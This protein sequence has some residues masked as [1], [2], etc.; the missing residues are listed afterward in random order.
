MF[1]TNNSASVNSA[2]THE[3]LATAVT[4][5]LKQT[6]DF[7][8]SNK[9]LKVPIHF[10]YPI[11]CSTNNEQQAVHFILIWTFTTLQLVPL[12]EICCE[13][14]SHLYCCYLCDV[15]VPWRKRDILTTI[16]FLGN[17]C[18]GK[19]SNNSLWS[20]SAVLL[21]LLWNHGQVHGP[22]PAGRQ[23]HKGLWYRTCFLLY[24]HVLFVFTFLTLTKIILAL[25]L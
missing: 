14:C 20:L 21:V 13:S 2:T 24:S 6:A 8:T 4:A 12:P 16:C 18:M 7:N 25:N 11:C 5:V 17:L 1:V 10:Y 23:P 19:S 22:V 15:I 3:V 9:L